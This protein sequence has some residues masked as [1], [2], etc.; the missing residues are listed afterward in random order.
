M[1]NIILIM[2]IYMETT[3]LNSFNTHSKVYNPKKYKMASVSKVREKSPSLNTICE[4]KMVQGIF[5]IVSY[6]VKSEKESGHSS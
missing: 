4:Y 2:A 3:M 1:T 6:L 5:N